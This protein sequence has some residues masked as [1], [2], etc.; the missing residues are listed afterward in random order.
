[1]GTDLLYGER[2]ENRPAVRPEGWELTC[3]TARGVELNCYIARGWELT[4][5]MARGVG[6]D[7]LDGER[8][9][10]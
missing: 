2:G 7:L 1:M 8:G 3:C 4:C 5:C 9:G 6:T 10:N